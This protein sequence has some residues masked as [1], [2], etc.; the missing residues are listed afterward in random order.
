MN[1]IYLIGNISSD[2]KQGQTGNG[3]N[4]CRFS[5]AVNRR[6]AKP[7][8]NVQTDFF[9]IVCWRGLAEACVKSLSKGKKCA[10]SGECQL[11][12]YQAKDG[13]TINTVEILADDVE[14]LSP[15]DPQQQT[16]QTQSDDMGVEEQQVGEL[17]F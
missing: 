3:V 11:N 17:P 12:K 2:V 6:F 10:I 15:R 8:D 9:N 16:M 1:K 7:S 5:L 14:F 13:T 4:Y